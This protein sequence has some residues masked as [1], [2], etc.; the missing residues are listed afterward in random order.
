MRIYDTL[1]GRVRDFAPLDGKA[2]RMYVCGV[3]PYAEA[4]VG[5]AMQAIVFDV[6]RRHLEHRGYV[7]RH[8][9]N[10]TDID[11][12]LIDRANQEGAP[13]ADLAERHIAAY[14]RLLEALNVRP[15]HH[16]P[17]ATEQTPQMLEIIGGLVAR[18]AA[19]ASAGDVY[20]RVTRAPGYGK[21]S[22]RSLEMMFAG[23]RIEAN[24]Q[25]EHPMDFALWK[26]AKPGEPSWDSPWGPGRPG[27]HIECSAMALNYLGRTLDIHGGGQDLVFPHHENEIAQSE[28]FNDGQPLARFWMHN[29][30]ML[31]GQEKM[32]K[33]LGNLV[34]IADAL[35]AHSADALRHLILSSHYRSP[36]TY[37]DDLM[38]ASGRAVARLRQALA[39]SGGAGA[40]LNPDPHRARFL[41]AMDDDFSPPQALASLFD[42]AR[43]VNRAAAEG[44]DVQAAQEALRTLGGEVIGFAFA[45]P[46]AAV[47]PGLARRIQDL[48]DR[49]ARLRAERRF[50]EADAIRDELAAMNVSLTDSPQGAVWQ[51]TQ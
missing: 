23:A 5:H 12:K 30:M 9:Q 43:A 44:G 2:A 11:D 47:D 22:R 46:Q 20:F 1:E 6:V 39:V 26:A 35:A 27:W 7:V 3:T 19:Y 40:A 4:H 48:V 33:S 10:F 24:A 29:G 17:R 14:F 45:E 37:S 31:L 13:V 16:Y 51:L 36:V 21:L 18:G 41:D 28:A 42:L 8:V 25:K 49:R 38:A 32:S 34:T 15:A 50:A